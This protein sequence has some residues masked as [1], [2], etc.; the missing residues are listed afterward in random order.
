MKT[1]IVIL[2]TLFSVHVDMVAQ[3]SQVSE[4]QKRLKIYQDSLLLFPK[5]YEN[6]RYTSDSLKMLEAIKRGMGIEYNR[7]E[8][9]IKYL[10]LDRKSKIQKL[11]NKLKMLKEKKSEIEEG[12]NT[13]RFR[14]T[15]QLGKTFMCQGDET[16]YKNSLGVGV[17]VDIPRGDYKVVSIIQDIPNEIIRKFGSSYGLCAVKLKSLTTKKNYNIAFR[18]NDESFRLRFT[19]YKTKKNSR[20]SF[21]EYDEEIHNLES[22]I[23]IQTKALEEMDVNNHMVSVLGEINRLINQE[24]DRIASDVSLHARLWDSVVSINNRI[25]DLKVETAIAQQK[26]EDAERMKKLRNVYGDKAKYVFNNIP[27][28]GMPVSA[29]RDMKQNEEL[30][31]DDGVRKVYKVYSVWNYIR[32]EKP[33]YLIFKNDKLITIADQFVTIH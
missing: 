23:A 5:V 19:D 3:I 13:V 10:K 9:S 4:L 14:L 20:K 8:D 17:L 21:T 12:I 28:V 11:K 30:V 31:S 32:D 27:F 6:G 7:I 15:D 18:E 29:L 2:I 24:K 33:K 16:A 1:L 25:G 26:K 22:D